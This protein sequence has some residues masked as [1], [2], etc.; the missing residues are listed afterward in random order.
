[1]ITCRDVRKCSIN[2]CVDLCIDPQVKPSVLCVDR[3]NQIHTALLDFYHY[4]FFFVSCPYNAFIYYI[5][6]DNYR[7]EIL[8]HVYQTFY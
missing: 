4:N 7:Q 1:M 6:N 5:N 8:E 3:L 2:P